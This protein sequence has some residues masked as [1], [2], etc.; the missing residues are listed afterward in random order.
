MYMLWKE[1]SQGDGSFEYLQHLFCLRNIS[2]FHSYTW[3][4]D[5]I[6]N[7]NGKD[8]VLLKLPN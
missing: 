4:Y 8:L 3:T 2:E 5:A 7:D 1:P 6:V